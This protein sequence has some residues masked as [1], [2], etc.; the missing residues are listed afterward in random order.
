MSLEFEK[1]FATSIT[2]LG[3]LRFIS[4]YLFSTV[5]PTKLPNVLPPSGPASTVSTRLLLMEKSMAEYP[6]EERWIN[7]N[8]NLIIFFTDSFISFESA[9]EILRESFHLGP[10]WQSICFYRDPFNKLMTFAFTL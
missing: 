2:Q 6:A 5:D 8:S 1:Q 7:S 10:Y 9:L 4:H 3:E